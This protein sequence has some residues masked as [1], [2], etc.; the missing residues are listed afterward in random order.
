M[1]CLLENQKCMAI[2]PQELMNGFSGVRERGTIP[3]VYDIDLLPRELPAELRRL[4]CVDKAWLQQL[5]L[6]KLKIL[7]QAY[8]KV[9]QPVAW[10]DEAQR[11]QLLKQADSYVL[12]M[13]AAIKV[14]CLCCLCNCNW[15]F[16][17][18]STTS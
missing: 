9:K 11:E 8:F 3:S 14:S 16:D 2:M 7:A 12:L 15:C 5:T 1:H 17:I 4:L 18:H 13:V 10:K 6:T